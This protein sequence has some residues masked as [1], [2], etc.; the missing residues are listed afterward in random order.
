MPLQGLSPERCDVSRV[1][2]GSL[3]LLLFLGQAFASLVQPQEQDPCR[4]QLSNQQVKGAKVTGPETVVQLARVISQPD[5]PS[6]ILAVDFEGTYFSLHN[7]Q[8]DWKPRYKIR[9]RN[10]SDQA[11][12]ALEVFVGIRDP[13]GAGV[14]GGVRS[15]SRSQRDKRARSLVT[16]RLAPAAPRRISFRFSLL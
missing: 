4:F 7:G 6:E 1:T 12:H 8:Y 13:R 3:V 5:S 14:G 2:V 11:I 15:R 10:R 9:L 16:E